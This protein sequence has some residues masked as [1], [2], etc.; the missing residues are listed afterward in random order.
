MADDKY[1]FRETEEEKARQEEL[2]TEV[3]Q[4]C[5]EEQLSFIPPE[6][7]IAR[8]H[9]FSGEFEQSMQEM[10]ATRGRRQHRRISSRE[11]TYGFNKIAAC[12]LVILMA[13][14]ILTGGYLALHRASGVD[15]TA[16]VETAAA[17][18]AEDTA[19]M[20]EESAE[21][22][23]ADGG[24][25]ER[26]TAKVPEQVSFAGQ[27]IDLASEQ[28]VSGETDTVKT[29][30]SCPVLTRD[31][32]EV[33]VTIGNMGEAAISYNAN[34][35]LQVQVDGAWYVVPRRQ[36]PVG[37]QDTTVVLEPGMAQDEELSFADYALD[38]DAEQYRV[39]TY[40][41]GV[42]YSAQ[43]RFESVE[44]GLEEALEE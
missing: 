2:L 35:E 14:G 3:L 9:R 28:E 7:E 21:D 11:F 42:P 20:A 33:K 13:G 43:F 27:S 1:T 34:M 10:C 31:A 22:S 29:L 17:D 36:E 39:L 16:Q 32:E 5:M 19:V 44:Q 12:I 15:S 23:A 37:Q 8:K 40:V 30:V 41:D 4:A 26:E 18:M 25:G 6:G 38:Y 24:T